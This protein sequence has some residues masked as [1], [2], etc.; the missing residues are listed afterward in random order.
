VVGANR[1]HQYTKQSVAEFL[2]W[3]NKNGKQSEACIVAF[4]L[5][6]AIDWGHTLA[7]KLIN[8]LTIVKVVSSMRLLGV[9][10]RAW[11]QGPRLGIP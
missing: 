1:P 5:M 8:W 6:D 9:P 10:P 3:I 4:N 11:A 7:D 2:G